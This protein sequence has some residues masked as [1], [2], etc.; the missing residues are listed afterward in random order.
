MDSV[1]QRESMKEDDETSQI[2]WEQDYIQQEQRVESREEERNR[3]DSE[4]VFIF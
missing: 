1:T 3:F 4:H 2:H